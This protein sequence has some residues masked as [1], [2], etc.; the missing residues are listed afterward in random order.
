MSRIGILMATYNGEKYLR[1][2]IESIQAQE[3]KY[4]DLYINDD[5]SSDLTVPI[6]QEYANNDSR[7]HMTH[8]DKSTHGQLEN[9]GKLLKFISCKDYDYIMFADQD[10]IWRTSKI[11]DTVNFIKSHENGPAMVYTNYSENNRKQVA[12]YRCD[13]GKEFGLSRLLIQNWTMGCTMMI[14][15]SLLAIL[16]NVPH[17]ADNHDNWVMLVALTYGDIFYLDEITMLHRIHENNVTNNLKKRN[18]KSLLR[19]FFR[20]AT[21][22]QNFCK[23]KK[24]LMEKILSLS[25]D[26]KTSYVRH[27]YEIL[28]CSGKAKRICLLERGKYRGLNFHET[29][30]LWFTI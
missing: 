11:I 15:S 25:N 19:H 27:F 22:H 13:F 20:E 8:L 4:W 28:N 16:G 14:N 5:G 10:D 21:D 26:E 18:V 12:R 23:K 1:E 3:Y 30:K 24:D 17:S 2:Q 29:I 6:A 9:F 7:I